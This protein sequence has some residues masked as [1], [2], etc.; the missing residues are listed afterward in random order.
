MLNNGITYCEKDLIGHLIY[1]KDR[2]FCHMA[3]E[4]LEYDNTTNHWEKRAII[5]TNYWN[6]DYNLFFFVN[7]GNI[8][9]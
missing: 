2:I 3:N 7:T 6:R 9:Y 4:W 5:S 1:Y 8:S